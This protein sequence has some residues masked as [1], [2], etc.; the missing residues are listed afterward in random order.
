MNDRNGK[1]TKMTT[2]T[3]VSATADAIQRKNQIMQLTL[4]LTVLSFFT[5]LITLTSSYWVVVKYPPDFFAIK[6]NMYVL[7][8]TYGVIWEC[9]RGRPT[10]NAR[11]RKCSLETAT[12]F[13]A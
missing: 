11:P 10:K 1:A 5:F 12:L 3:P 4:A 8:T 2:V 7:E 6:H 13:G 9:V